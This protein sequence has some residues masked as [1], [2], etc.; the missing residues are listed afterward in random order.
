MENLANDS[1]RHNFYDS[2]I[3]AKFRASVKWLISRTY[4]G[5]SIPDDLSCLLNENCFTIQ[6]ALISILTNGS[7]YGQTLARQ[8]HDNS[9]LNH[10]IKGILDLLSSRGIIA[11]DKDGN[12]LDP[13]QLE[14]KDN[15]EQALHAQFIDTLIDA[16]V[17][18]II[19]V[20]K[21]VKAISSYAKV[22]KR[23]EPLDHID[24]LLFWINK[25]CSL[26]RDN[27]EDEQIPLRSNKSAATI[28]EMEDLYD[29]LSDG[30]SVATLLS[31]YCSSDISIREI[32]F[33]DPMTAQDCRSNFHMIKSFCS[34]HFSW[35]PFHFEV[36]D[37][38]NINETLH[39]NI[40]AF[41][42]DL[43]KFFESGDDSGKVTVRTTHPS[44][45]NYI[46]PIPGL[47]TGINQR[48]GMIGHARNANKTDSLMSIDSLLT[49][50]SATVNRNQ[51]PL[52]GMD[53]TN[54]GSLSYETFPDNND[55]I[56]SQETATVKR[57]QQKMEVKLEM[58]KI[59]KNYGQKR[60]LLSSQQEQLKTDTTKNAFFR[61]M[62]KSMNNPVTNND[63]NHREQNNSVGQQVDM[64]QNELN[65]VHINEIR[66]TPQKGQIDGTPRTHISNRMPNSQSFHENIAD[67]QRS[68]ETEKLS[69]FF[70]GLR[71]E[72]GYHLDTTPLHSQ[73]TPIPQQPIPSF[74]PNFVHPDQYKYMSSTNPPY[75]PFNSTFQF[76]PLMAQQASQ[77]QFHSTPYAAPPF[78]GHFHHQLSNF[79]VPNFTPIQQQQ[80][81]PPYQMP[82]QQAPPLFSYQQQFS[83]ELNKYPQNRS[84]TSNNFHL[85]NRDFNEMMAIDP[86]L[87]LGKNQINWGDSNLANSKVSDEAHSFSNETASPLADVLTPSSTSKSSCRDLC[88]ENHIENADVKTRHSGGVALKDTSAD[89]EMTVEMEAK[90]QA[91][92]SS[93]M[94]RKEQISAKTEERDLQGSEKRQNE[95]YRQERSEQRKIEDKLRRQKLL[96]EYKKKKMEEIGNL[97][98]SSVSPTTSKSPYSDDRQSVGKI[99]RPKSQ[100]NLYTI[101]SIVP[102]NVRT[103]SNLNENQKKIVVPSI[104]EPSLKLFAKNQPKSNRTIMTNAVQYSIFPGTVTSDQRNKAQ[105]AMAQSDLKHFLVL[106]RD[107]KCQYRGLYTW[108]QYSDTVH[109]I[110]GTGPKVCTE[111]MMALMFK[112]DSGAKSFSPIPT[113]HLSA[114]VDAFSIADHYWQKAKAPYSHR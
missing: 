13:T 39:P 46:Q 41:L 17:K 101:N 84:P 103:R 67:I 33:N 94:K 62:S 11:H 87:D 113:K 54:F 7:I 58:E 96:E 56:S 97:P 30:T 64:L 82:N 102:R 91:L 35:N 32:C 51:R 6:P 20:E 111:S 24:A 70:S 78:H 98:G 68:S 65:N 112:Y 61:V 2:P 16:Y 85:H 12:S 66:E 114:T 15:F 76:Q 74:F 4:E 57:S 14:S 27:V 8:F 40:N 50:R 38:L 1:M 95:L 63:I 86:Q 109:R 45:F 107:Q 31:F 43:F 18:S 77:H 48:D 37:M 104:A 21:I 99:S 29:D 71:A 106:F 44:H 55:Q 83:D 52:D 69:N 81:F 23:E 53:I 89:S 108:D 10:N 105:A 9:F 79:P 90:R 88:S 5:R 80:S 26:V 36:D 47:R 72:H 22:D 59:R 73:F 28:P 100:S 34:T 42:A 92:L 19:S 49:N 3:Q 110:D 75:Q 25:I 60:Q 93:Q